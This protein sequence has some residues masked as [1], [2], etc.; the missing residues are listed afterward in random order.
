[1]VASDP[2]ELAR[3]VKA[4]EQRWRKIVRENNIKPD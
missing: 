3:Y 2:A 4:E 1:V